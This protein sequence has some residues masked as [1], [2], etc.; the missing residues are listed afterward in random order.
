MRT[1]K[2]IKLKNEY[3]LIIPESIVKLYDIKENQIFNLEVKDSTS[4]LD[5]VI[6]SYSTT[7]K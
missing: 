7:A 6:L 3:V 5:L 1:T 4:V 2:A